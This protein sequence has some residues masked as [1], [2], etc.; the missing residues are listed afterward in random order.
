VHDLRVVTR[1]I[2]DFA[3]IGVPVLNPWEAAR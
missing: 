1:N 2:A 3:A